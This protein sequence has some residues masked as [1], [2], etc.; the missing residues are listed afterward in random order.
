MRRL[1]YLLPLALFL[2]IAGYFAATLRSGRDPQALPSAMIDKPMPAIDLA[3]LD[4]GARVTSSSF[5]GQVVLINFFA[6][7]CVPC[8]EEQPLLL[9]LKTEN[10]V[11]VIG[12]AYKDKPQDTQRFLTQLGDPFQRIGLDQEGQLALNFGV[13]GVPETYVI[14]KDGRIRYRQ[15]SVITPEIWEETILPLIK[16]L[17]AS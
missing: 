8:R 4:N 16:K 17:A 2:V 15:I 11:P 12:I 10:T 6:S 1:L 13:Y 9:R 5:A 14:G 3:A 7:W